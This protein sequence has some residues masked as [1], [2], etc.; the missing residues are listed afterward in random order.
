MF[1]EVESD[2]SALLEDGVMTATV[3]TR[4]DTYHIEVRGLS[5]CSPPQTLTR[6]RGGWRRQ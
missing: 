5:Y 4:Q 6:P 3:R 2:V 1:G